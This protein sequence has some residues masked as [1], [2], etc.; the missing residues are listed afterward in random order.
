MPVYFI[1]RGDNGPV[2]IGHSIEPYGRLKSLSMGGPETYRL[3]AWIDGDRDK[4]RELHKKFSDARINGEWFKLN[5]ELAN[6]IDQHPP[7]S[8]DQV[9]HYNFLKANNLPIPKGFLDPI[10]HLGRVT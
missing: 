9:K 10:P 5:D 8:E 7:P 6:L 2:K 4:E 3:V 1:K